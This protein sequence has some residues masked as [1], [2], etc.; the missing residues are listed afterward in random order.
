MLHRAQLGGRVAS[1]KQSPVVPP[2]AAGFD[3]MVGQVSVRLCPLE[4]TI[5]YVQNNESTP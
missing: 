4:V 1:H 5:W 2:S 3:T